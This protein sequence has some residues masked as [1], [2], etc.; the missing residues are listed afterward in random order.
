MSGFAS[1]LATTPL[2]R[3]GAGARLDAAA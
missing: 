2:Q 3:Q 1:N